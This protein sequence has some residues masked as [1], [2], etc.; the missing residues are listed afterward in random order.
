M[1][2]AFDPSQGA[3]LV[4]AKLTGP[5][6]A[7]E[8]LLA[9][10]TGATCSMVDENLLRAA[11]LDPSNPTGKVQATFG[12]GVMTLPMVTA[13][14]LSALGVSRQNYQVV[15]HTLPPSAGVDG[16]LGLDFFAGHVLTIDFVQHTVSLT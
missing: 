15:C 4:A 16:V 1:T 14:D 6:A 13:T 2:H 5:A 12:G 8:L 3:I 11:G 10:D 9:L 7:V